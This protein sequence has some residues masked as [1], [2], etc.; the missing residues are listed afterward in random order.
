MQKVDVHVHVFTKLSDKFPRQVG[1]LAP[2]ERQGTAEEL[3]REM[4]ANGIDRTVLIDMGGTKI[5]HHTYVT[6]CVNTWPDRF[7]ATGLVDDND[8]DPPARL[9][10]LV[11]ATQIEGIRLS[12]LGDPTA[13]RAEDLKTYGLFQCAAELGLNINVYSSNNQ[14]GCLEMLIAAFPTVNVSL[15]HLG[16]L[17]TTPMVPDRW[18]RPR[19]DD[20][21]LPTPTFPKILELAQYPNV[22]IK[23]SGEYAFSKV[24]YPY[25]DMKSM[26][27]QVYQAYGADRMM[28]CTDSPWILVEPGYGKLVT[29]LDHHLPAISSHEREM[30]MGGTALKIWFKRS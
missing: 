23:V 25:G 16:V 15:D 18:G 17:P 5:E 11:E 27:E 7:T 8:E 14:V 21:P 1:G 30:I 24:P 26:V 13:T 4:D 10:E 20:E 9:R 3:L 2:A 28:W 6:H 29:L 19:F 12:S 22:Y